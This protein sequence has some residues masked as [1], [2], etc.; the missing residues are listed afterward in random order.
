MYGLKKS[1]CIHSILVEDF[2][3]Y[4]TKQKIKKQHCLSNL[5]MSVAY[6]KV[7][8]LYYFKYSFL[9]QKKL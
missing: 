8:I 2:Q 5:P 9:L 7:L 3:V 4:K 6:F 1:Y